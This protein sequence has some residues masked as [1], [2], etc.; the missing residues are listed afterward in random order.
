ML[1]PEAASDAASS[2]NGPG[3]RPWTAVAHQGKGGTDAITGRIPTWWR[4]F[5][6]AAGYDC[7]RTNPTGFQTD[8]RPITYTML[9]AMSPYAKRASRCV[10][11]R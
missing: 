11:S 10:E 1:D 3:P 7:N 6:E 2:S 4:L 8:S 5:S 9:D